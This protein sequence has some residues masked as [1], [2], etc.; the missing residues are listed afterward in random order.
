[1]TTSRHAARHKRHP[2][3]SPLRPR[4]VIPG[5][6][7]VKRSDQEFGMTKLAR[8]PAGVGRGRAIRH[9]FGGGGSPCRRLIRIGAGFATSCAAAV[10]VNDAGT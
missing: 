10:F 5:G 9:V 7:R 1:M 3:A 6:Q 8:A 4:A 2:L